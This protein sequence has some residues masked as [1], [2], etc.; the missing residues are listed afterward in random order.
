MR[1]RGGFIGRALGVAVLG[2]I[3]GMAGMMAAVPMHAAGFSIFEQGTK[4]MGMAGAFTAQADDP[5]MLF[6]NAGG[7]AFVEERA[8]STGVTWITGTEAELRGRRPVPRPRRDRPSRSRCPSSRP[9]P[10]GCSR[11]TTPGSSA[12]AS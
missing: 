12:S 2:T 7:L 10:T 9:T 1:R 8:F 3:A 11:S 5:S 6:H 4:A